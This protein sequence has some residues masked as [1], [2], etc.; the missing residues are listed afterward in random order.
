[1]RREVR[2]AA[3]R[4]GETGRA[5]DLKGARYAL[6]KDPTDLTERQRTKLAW[7]A[8]TNAPLYRAYLLGGA[9]ADGLRSPG[10]GGDGVAR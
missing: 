5:N 7:I 10:G 8:R 6:W 9:A 4:A 2:D 1:M 3:R